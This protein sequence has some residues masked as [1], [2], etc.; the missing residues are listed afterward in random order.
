MADTLEEK[1]WKTSNTEQLP[2]VSLQATKD[3][4][5]RPKAEK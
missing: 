2:S 3:R 5:E 4:E 1:L